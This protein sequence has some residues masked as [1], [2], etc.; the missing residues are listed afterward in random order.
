MAGLRPHLEA[1]VNALA[2]ESDAAKQLASTRDRVEQAIHAARVVGATYDELARV[3]SR[4]RLGR[5]PSIAERLREAA[6][7]PQR[8]YSVRRRD[9][10]LGST[11]GQHASS[12]SRS[13]PGGKT[14]PK[15]RTTKTTTEIIEELI[16]DEDEQEDQEDNDDITEED[17]HEEAED[18]SHD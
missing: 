9:T 18:E 12:W 7:L 4:A 3:T 13:G 2:A 6:R 17:L 1:L 10:H 15:L 16:D 14:M 5:P 8:V 11:G